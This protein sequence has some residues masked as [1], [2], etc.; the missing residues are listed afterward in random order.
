MDGNIVT[1]CY[2]AGSRQRGVGWGYAIFIIEVDPSI[3]SFVIDGFLESY[4]KDLKNL[5]P[6][7]I[8]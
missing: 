5:P 7:M 1:V 6:E 4:V 8:L 2:T 3:Y